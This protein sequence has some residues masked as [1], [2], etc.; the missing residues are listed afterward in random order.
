MPK[1]VP[2]TMYTRPVKR[3]AV[4]IRACMEWRPVPIADA[5]RRATC[6]RNSKLPGTFVKSVVLPLV[7]VACLFA[8]VCVAYYVYVAWAPLDAPFAELSDTGRGTSRIPKI[9]HQVWKTDTIPDRWKEP[10]DM[11]RRMNPDFEIRLWSDEEALKFL[12]RFYPEF[13]ATYLSYQYDIQRA[14]AIRYFLLHHYGGVYMDLDVGC[15]MPLS[16]LL[17]GTSAGF[18]APVTSP[19]GFSN[20]VMAS[21]PGHP[22]AQMLIDSLPLWN[23]WLF[24]KY[25]TVRLKRRSCLLTLIRR[26]AGVR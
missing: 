9:I 21:I 22:L 14:D 7:L 16:R 5:W 15:R 1:R 24:T 6:R 2:S 25:P 26:I 13:A 3:I 18:L 23:I 8:I 17:N 11:V 20:D 10:A 19:L 4:L 12:Q